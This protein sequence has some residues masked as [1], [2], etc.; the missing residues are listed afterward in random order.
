MSESI[1]LR[2]MYIAP[3]L[4]PNQN[5]ILKGWLEKGDQVCFL[6]RKEGAIE[7]HSV[8]EP[9]ILGISTLCKRKNDNNTSESNIQYRN[10]LKDQNSFPP[11]RKLVVLMKEF[12]PNIV[13]I[14]DRSIYMFFCYWIA[15]CMGI[16]VILYNQSPIYTDN[17]SSAVKRWGQR[18]FFPRVRI[19]PVLQ[20]GRYVPISELE[21]KKYR[22]KEAHYVPFVM[23]GHCRPEDKT[24]FQ[25]DRINLLVVGRF[26]ERKQHF[27]MLEVMKQVVQNHRDLHMRLVGEC[28]NEQQSAYVIRLQKYILENELQEY[29]SLLQNLN[30]QQMEQE[31]QSADVFVLPSIEEP[32]AISPL[33]AMSYSVPC[34]SSD[35][36]GTASYI[37]PGKSGEIFHAGD[38]D[39]LKCK[40][41]WLLES[42]DR[43][44]E[45]GKEAYCYLENNCGFE[46]YRNA[47]TDILKN[48]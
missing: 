18:A 39:D 27:Q 38:T 6:S 48:R 37:V 19:T 33:E 34:I 40:L 9:I 46:Q 21:Q 17:R 1:K 3:R 16:P 12:R 32:A 26:E 13:I 43:I 5:P 36:N 8:L 22:D 31:Y 10:Y 28:S 30:S 24:Y 11:V 35:D 15:K 29:V 20:R 25:N 47:I 42:R 23:R 2:V 44:C 41:L 14:R 45:C 4:H 7:D